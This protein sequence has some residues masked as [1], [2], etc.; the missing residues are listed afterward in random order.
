MILYMKK[1]SYAHGQVL[2]HHDIDEATSQDDLYFHLHDRLG[3][4]R[5]FFADR[6]NGRV[7]N[8]LHT[9]KSAQDTVSQSRRMGF[10]NGRVCNLLHTR[11][12]AQDNASQ[13]RRMGFSPCRPLHYAHNHF[14]DGWQPQAKLG[15][16]LNA[17]RNPIE[18]ILGA[19]I[20][21]NVTNPFMFTGQ[22]FDS[23]IKEYYLRARQYNPHISNYEPQCHYTHTYTA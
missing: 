22:Y 3:S 7:C 18:P 11:K 8:L 17:I 9:R 20:E 13:S 19:E 5:T 6:S 23:E 10:S 12:S 15:D 1:Y 21:E 2:A 14:A 16:G 4:N